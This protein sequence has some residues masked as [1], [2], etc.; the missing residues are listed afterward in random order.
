MNGLT[1]YLV[2]HG[3]AMVDSTAAV[4]CCSSRGLSPS[5]FLLLLVAG[6]IAS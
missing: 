3:P 5:Q 1:G 4:S 6:F 2:D